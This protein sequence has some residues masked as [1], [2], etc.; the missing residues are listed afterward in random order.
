MKSKF[1]TFITEF[2]KTTVKD[3]ESLENVHK[4]LISKAVVE[5]REDSAMMNVDMIKILS[6][7]HLENRKLKTEIKN[8]KAEFKE[9]QDEW[10]DQREKLR[11]KIDAYGDK[12]NRL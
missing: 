1:T 5:E 8:Q 9:K 2:K 6:Y 4:T 7:L 10:A 12:I 3:L 11:D